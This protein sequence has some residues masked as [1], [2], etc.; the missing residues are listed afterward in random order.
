MRLRICSR[1]DARA[2][3]G[4]L[5]LT[6]AEPPPQRPAPRP[7]SAGRSRASR[8]ARRRKGGR[9]DEPALPDADRDAAGAAALDAG[10]ARDDHAPVQPRPVPGRAGRRESGPAAAC[11]CGYNLMPMHTVQR[12]DF[13]G[14]LGLSEG[15]LRDRCGRAV[16][17]A[18][19][20][21]RAEDV[22]RR[23]SSSITI[24]AISRDGRAASPPSEHD[25]DRTRARVRHQAG[26][27]AT[28]GEVDVEGEPREARE[29]FSA[30]LA[31]RR[32]RSRTSRPTI[33]RR[34]AR[35]V[36]ARAASS[37]AT[38][39]RRPSFGARP[40]GRM[41]RRSTST[42]DVQS[43]P[44]VTIAFAA[45]RCP[46]DKIDDLVPDRARRF[47]GRGSARGLDAADQRPTCSSRGTGKPT[48]SVEP[49]GGRGQLTIVFTVQRGPQYRVG[50]ARRRG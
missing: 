38:T 39:R 34:A 12:V 33:C 47:G 43:G 40:I 18:P 21:G 42:V 35:R 50:R 13:R 24:T 26:P 7:T 49:R 8:A 20:L 1:C 45:I 31:R 15:L 48:S 27:R 4:A 22:A 17:R 37:A 10:R 23:S 30:Q 28:I 44:L 16:R 9:L 5:A 36:R 29:G 46:N 19:P 2:L 14:Q 41:A 6:R 32:R 3:A 25:P 11:C